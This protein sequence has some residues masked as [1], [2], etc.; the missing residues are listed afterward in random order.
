MKNVL[1]HPLEDS[2]D[3]LMKR[4]GYVRHCTEAGRAC[5]HKRLNDPPFPRFHAFVAVNDKGMEV[6]LHFDQ[7]DSLKHKG[8][9]DKDWA[10][11]GGRVNGEMN[12][13]FRILKGEDTSSKTVNQSTARTITIPKSASKKKGLFEILFK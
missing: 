1:K 11:Q 7:F 10:Y 6:D 4:V 5:F 12:R 3:N 13:I 8:N 9:H 2:P